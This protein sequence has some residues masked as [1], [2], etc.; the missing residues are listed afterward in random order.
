MVKTKRDKT[1]VKKD[2]V[3]RCEEG[4]DPRFEKIVKANEFSHKKIR[5]N[6]RYAHFFVNVSAIYYKKILYYFKNY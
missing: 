4:N 3:S 6:C 2:H 1:I 5:K